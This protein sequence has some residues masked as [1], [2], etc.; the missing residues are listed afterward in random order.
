MRTEAVHVFA[1]ISEFYNGGVERANRSSPESMSCAWAMALPT[2]SF[3]S[4]EGGE[5]GRVKGFFRAANAL[6][7]ASCG[8]PA[9]YLGFLGG[10][11]RHGERGRY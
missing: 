8:G 2:V 6:V 3:V 11:Q 7:Q 4:A 10:I 9:G 1:L 5:G